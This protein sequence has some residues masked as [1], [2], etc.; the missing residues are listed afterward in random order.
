MN[1]FDQAIERMAIEIDQAEGTSIFIGVTD[2]TV[3][4]DHAVDTLRRRL[5]ADIT[6]GAFRY[7]TEY[8]SLLEGV[9]AA[10]MSQAGR[11]G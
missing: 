4:R 8:L 2:D 7:D 5:C 10:E 6:L 1:A 9:I 11:P 3:L